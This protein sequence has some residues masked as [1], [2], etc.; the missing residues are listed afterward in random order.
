MLMK[1]Q[2]QWMRRTSFLAEVFVIARI[3]IHLQTVKFD[4]GSL[5]T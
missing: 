4:Y 5:Q 3:N 2:K 1:L